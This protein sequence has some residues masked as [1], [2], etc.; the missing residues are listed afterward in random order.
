[1]ATVAATAA[2][3]AATSGRHW[4]PEKNLTGSAGSDRFTARFDRFYRFYRFDPGDEAIPAPVNRLDVNRLAPIVA[5]RFAKQ[6]DGLEQR[7]LGDEG[8]G[9]DRVHQLLLGSDHARAGDER[10]QNAQRAWRQ[11]H[12]VGA[13]PEPVPSDESER[14]KSH[15]FSVSSVHLQDSAGAWLP[16]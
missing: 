3:L 14:P 11:R 6:A 4:G 12:L 1:M 15:D 7:R 9:P 13:F 5:E 2:T 8:V 10:G 16:F